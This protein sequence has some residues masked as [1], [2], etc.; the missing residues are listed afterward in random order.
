MTGLLEGF[1][2]PQY[3]PV[4]SWI[5][6][7]AI[8]LLLIYLAYRVVR[9]LTSGTFIAGGR[10]R[11]TRL[12]VMDAA[13][14]DDKRRL[15]LVR[16]D[17]VEHLILIGGPT[18]VVVEQDIRMIAKSTRTL[19]GE[20][21]STAE[22]TEFSAEPA[23][24]PRPPVTAP[25]R[26]PHREGR[27]PERPIA[28]RPAT[29]RAAPPVARPASASQPASQPATPQ[30]PAAPQQPVARSAPTVP[31]PSAAPATPPRQEATPRP[32]AAV[33]P[34]APR[35]EPAKSGYFS[36]FQNRPSQPNPPMTRTPPTQG[37]APAPSAR[38]AAVAAPTASPASESL[39]DT[40]LQELEDSLELTD[41]GGNS[42]SDRGLEDE[43]SKL[44]GEL[45][46][47]RK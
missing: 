6:I 44:L 19:P 29:E 40:L 20:Q 17:D 16:R 35:P 8:A 43:M 3:V 41:R 33:Q 15:V 21:T 30:P 31:P 22:P 14:V 46:R 25:V 13:A 37:A 7:A 42:S 23:P 5:I 24:A 32:A 36:S 2:D 26:P 12:A 47:D 27:L 9:M 45:S 10:N 4:V 11:R 39:D 38:P 18:D 1:L 34:P 28:S